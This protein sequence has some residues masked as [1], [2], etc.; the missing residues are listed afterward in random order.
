MPDFSKDFSTWGGKS[1]PSKTVPETAPPQSNIPAPVP[2]PVPVLPV[3]SSTGKQK[4]AMLL[5]MTGKA[6]EV[7]EAMLNAAQLAMADLGVNEFEL[8]LRDTAGTPEVARAVATKAIDE[9][10]TLILGPL[11]AEDTKAVA[12]VAAQNNIN[13]IS[14]ST[15]VSAVSTNSFILGFLPQS[16]IARV[17][18]FAIKH[19][20]LNIAIIAPRDQYGDASMQAF[21][22][23]MSARNNP[24][25]AIIRYTGASPSANDLNGLNGKTIDAIVIATNAQTANGI[26]NALSGMG[27][28]Q[29][30]VTR[31]GTGLWDSAE[32]AKLSALQ[33]AF[34]AASAPESRA[35]FEKRYREVYG[36]TPPRLA[37]LGYDAAALAIVLHKSGRGFGREALLNPNGFSGVDGIF[38]FRSDGLNERG[39]AVMQIQNNAAGVIQPAPMSFV[40]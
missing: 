4:I 22:R 1:T 17:V 29:N 19:N 6:N 13:V 38:R 26:S 36:V 20:K 16:Q 30:K 34:Y 33:G 21:D 25:V 40:Q 5:P 9:G 23:V 28:D 37:S 31:L 24:P 39:L 15:D 27:F 18:D 8:M 12:P 3:V 11:F 7:G 10:A 2:V 32:A 35:R 14:F